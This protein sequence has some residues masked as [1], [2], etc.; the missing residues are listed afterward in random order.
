MRRDVGCLLVLGLFA[1]GAR[2]EVPEAF[3]YS[4]PIVAPQ[5]GIHMGGSPVAIRA[6]RQK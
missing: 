1:V 6:G 4:W 3:A 2:A 5:G